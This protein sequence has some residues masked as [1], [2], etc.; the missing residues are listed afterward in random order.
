MSKELRVSID[1][2]NNNIDDDDA[3]DDNDT[4]DGGSMIAASVHLQ[5]NATEPSPLLMEGVSPELTEEQKK[6]RDRAKAQL[7]S[8]LKK[9]KQSYWVLE[10]DGKKRR[11]PAPRKQLFPPSSAPPKKKTK[12]SSAPAKKKTQTKVSDLFYS[13][14]ERKQ[15]D[16]YIHEVMTE[17]RSKNQHRREHDYSQDY[18]CLLYTSPSPRDKCRSRMPSSA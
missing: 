5:R 1:A 16:D 10:D 7:G 11:G 15:I 14:E 9:D 13:A 2:M 6:K 3:V 17:E 4:G 12:V 18:S 8:A